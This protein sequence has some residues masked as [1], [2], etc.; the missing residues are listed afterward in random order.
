MIFR[1]SE[2]C[3]IGQQYYLQLFQNCSIF[4]LTFVPQLKVSLDK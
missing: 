2:E 3:D 4:L 1:D